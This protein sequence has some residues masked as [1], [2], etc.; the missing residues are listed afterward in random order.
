[1]HYQLELRRS[2]TAKQGLKS[3]VLAD[4]G[5]APTA[6]AEGFAVVLRV[7][8]RFDESQLKSTG[9]F[10]DTD[11]LDEYLDYYAAHLISDT[12]TELFDFRPTYELVAR[13]V[14]QKL[15]PD[16]TGLA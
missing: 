6:P 2:F 11:A 13:W 5:K 16:I 4:Q 15:E 10:V 8:V 12:W 7:G 14:F 9:W 1:M 3:P